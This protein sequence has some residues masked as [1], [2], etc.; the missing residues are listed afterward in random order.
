MS[1]VEATFAAAFAYIIS[2]HGLLSFS[3]FRLITLRARKKARW[4]EDF[5]GVAARAFIT[6]F[7]L[8]AFSFH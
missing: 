2:F 5:R 1:L 6:I 4:S 3:C 7:S 8:I